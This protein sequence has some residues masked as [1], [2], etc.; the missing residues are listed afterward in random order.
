MSRF[1][2]GCDRRQPT[3]LPDCLDDYVA[4]E[5]PV[6][7]VDVFVDDL[8]L[9]VLGFEGVTPAATGRPAYHPAT[10]LKLY[11]YG[12]L[13]KVQSSRRLEREAGRNV[14]LMWLTGRLAPDH[15]TIADFRKE[16]G[17]AIQGACAQFVVL[18]RQI[19]LFGSTLVAIDGSKFK[20]V[21]SRDKNF[22][23]HK[24]TRRLQQVAEHIAGYLRDLDTADRQEDEAAEARSGRLQEKVERLREQMKMLKAMEAQ[25]AASPEGQISLTDPDARSMATSGRGSGIVGYNVQSAVEAKHHLIV[26]HDVV[27]TG[28][29]REQLAAMAAKAKNA[30]G[31][32]KL[33]ALADRGYFSGEEIRS[34]EALGVTPYLPK[35]L[36][37]GAKAEG[38]F[39]KQDFVYLPEQDVYRC[40][41]G[42]LLPRHMTTVERGMTLHRYWDRASCQ[43]CALKAQCTP[44]VERRVT[45]WEHEA[46]IDALQRRMDLTPGAMRQRRRLV[47]HPFGTIKAWMG[48]THFLT[49]RLPNV[50]TEIGLHIL[51][52]NL[53][54]VIAIIGAKPLMEAIRA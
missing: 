53:K 43:A 42:A 41:S 16:N 31:A 12:Y 1:V 51:A 11:I 47:E 35:P 17:P 9:E 33:D 18:C 27:M 50:K 36:T 45:R 25:V 46:I 48:A 34:C 52:Y 21:N 30:M 44:S 20:A 15:K 49:R 29:D 22:T 7:V 6:R 26:A 3:L 13:N 39:G 4:D 37:S 10:L 38:R 24:L 28:S 8:D 19:G 23:A 32:E 5:N 14:E 2:E 54:R 40:P